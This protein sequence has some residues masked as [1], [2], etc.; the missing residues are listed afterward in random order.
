MKTIAVEIV[1][2]SIG[3]ESE[4]ISTARFSARIPVY[5]SLQTRIIEAETVVIRAAVDMNFLAGEAID[6]GVRER[7]AL[8]DRIAEGI[9][10]IAGDHGL[11]GVEHVGDVAVAVGE[12]VVVGGPVAAGVAG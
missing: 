10:A 4:K 7:T 9:V 11:A 5:P 12:V 6:I 8:A 2:W 3:G 1:S